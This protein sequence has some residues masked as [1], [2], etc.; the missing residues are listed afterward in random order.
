VS[1]KTQTHFIG[2]N[3]GRG[4]LTGDV[5][6]P[7]GGKGTGNGDEV[8]RSQVTGIK[9]P[10]KKPKNLEPQHKNDDPPQEKKPTSAVGS[11]AGGVGGPKYYIHLNKI[12]LSL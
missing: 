1:S 9:G 10:Q 4:T 5:N 7:N 6:G 3:G 2:G 11:G 8:N 12:L